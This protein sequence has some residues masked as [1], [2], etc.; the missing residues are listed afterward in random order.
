[1]AYG[2][3]CPSLQ[4][5]DFVGWVKQSVMHSLHKHCS[6]AMYC[7][8][9]NVAQAKG[10]GCNYLAKKLFKIKKLQCKKN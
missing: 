3:G 7:S 1:M 10:C 4:T 9:H 8:E 2:F 6:E 5:E